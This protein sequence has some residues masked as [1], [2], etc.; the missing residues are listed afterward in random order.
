MT[1][2]GSISNLEA[3][4]RELLSAIAGA[5]DLSAL[6]QV[7]VAALGKKGRVSELMARLGSLAPEERK[8]FGQAVNELKGRVADTLEA[9]KSALEVAALSSRLANERSDVT[10]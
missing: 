4:E 10:L 3:L 2:A 5:G 8:A 7:R 6:E 9:R 1:S